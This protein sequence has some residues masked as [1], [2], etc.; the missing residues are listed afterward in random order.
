[1]VT[2]DLLH[3]LLDSRDAVQGK[4]VQGEVAR[5]RHVPG[6]VPEVGLLGVL[7][8]DGVAG[9]VFKIFNAPVGPQV[10]AEPFAVQVLAAGD[11]QVIGDVGFAW[12]RPSPISSSYAL[13]IPM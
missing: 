11:V 12:S 7:I 10:P 1:V 13:A 6:A 3:L 9:L 8:P 4:R 5:R 2:A